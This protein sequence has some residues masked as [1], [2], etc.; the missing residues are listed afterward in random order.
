[1]NVDESRDRVFIH[2]LDDEL[3]DADSEEE[4]LIFI[5]DIEKRLTKIPKSLLTSNH[6]QHHGSE[7]VLYGVPGSLSLP[8]DQDNVRKAIIESRQRARENQA[9]EAR[10]PPTQSST[11]SSQVVQQ[12]GLASPGLVN[13]DTHDPDAM[14]IG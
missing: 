12:P 5:A 4:K 10:A 6:P 7:I 11:V 1:M 13:G 2:N 9:L 8:K 3:A 14:E